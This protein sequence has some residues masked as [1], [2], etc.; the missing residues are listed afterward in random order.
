MSGILKGIYILGVLVLL[1]SCRVLYDKSPDGW[2]AFEARPSVGVSGFPP[3]TT[4]YGKAFRDGCG[5]AWDAVTL[6]VT[7]NINPM[8]L[9][10][11]KAGNDPDYRSGWWDGFEQCT[12][13]VDWDVV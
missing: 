4:V 10:S 8:A 9:D 11:V 2:P 5:S 3:P 6:G 12:Y 1:Q 13:I 7:S